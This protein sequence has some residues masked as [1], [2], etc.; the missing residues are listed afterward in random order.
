MSE[1]LLPPPFHFIGVGWLC[2]FVC[3]EEEGVSVILWDGCVVVVF[4][5]AEE[6]MVSRKRVDGWRSGQLHTRRMGKN[7]AGTFSSLDFVL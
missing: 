6:G 1:R 3:G 2:G 7:E 5:G 4:G